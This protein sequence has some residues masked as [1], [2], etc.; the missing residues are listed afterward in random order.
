MKE[1]QWQRWCRKWTKVRQLKGVRDGL[2]RVFCF[3]LCQEGAGE[4]GVAVDLV[5][6]AVLL[7]QFGDCLEKQS[8]CGFRVTFDDRQFGDGN[9]LNRNGRVGLLDEINGFLV[10]LAGDLEEC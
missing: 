10:M 9:L 1:L 4:R 3:A 2:G 8:L 5:A 6:G 7:F